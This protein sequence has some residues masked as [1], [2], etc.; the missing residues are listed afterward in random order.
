M[1]FR[2]VFRSCRRDEFGARRQF[3]WRE[4]FFGFRRSG[5]ETIFLEQIERADGAVEIAIGGGEIAEAESEGGGAF[6]VG[7]RH[8]RVREFV[9]EAVGF[10]ADF[11][12]G[13]VVGEFNFEDPRLD[14]GE[15]VDAPRWAL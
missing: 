15:A 8:E 13:L 5:G 1:R 11:D 9:V 12:G 2:A 7:L 3:V 14:G 6:G 10:E 4:H